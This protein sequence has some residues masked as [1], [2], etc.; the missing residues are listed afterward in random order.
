[1]PNRLDIFLNLWYYIDNKFGKPPVCKKETKT[2]TQLNK[3][4]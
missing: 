1:M 4:K 2:K 3:G